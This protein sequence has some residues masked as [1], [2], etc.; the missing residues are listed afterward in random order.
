[1]KNTIKK[2]GI[3][4]LAILLLVI[5]IQGALATSNADSCY[6][7]NNNAYDSCGSY[8]GTLMTGASYVTSY[9]TYNI[10]GD[11]S[12]HSMEVTNV[13]DNGISTS[14]DLSDRDWETQES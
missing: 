14:R 10:D 9:P 5:T 13:G 11:G 4:L 7:L 6:F 1:M 8:N 12:T 3:G 2:I